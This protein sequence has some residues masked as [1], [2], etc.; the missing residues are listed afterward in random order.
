MLHGRAKQRESNGLCSSIS[1]SPSVQAATC[2]QH[3]SRPHC[4]LPHGQ[5][6]VGMGLQKALGELQN[7]S[8]EVIGVA[9]ECLI[10]GDSVAATVPAKIPHLQ[11][12][13]SSFLPCDWAQLAWQSEISQLLAYQKRR[14]SALGRLTTKLTIFRVET[15]SHEVP[16]LMAQRQRK[17]VSLPESS[18]HSQASVWVR[19][20]HVTLWYFIYV[21]VM[22]ECFV[23]SYSGANWILSLRIVC[24]SGP[25]KHNWRVL[26]GRKSTT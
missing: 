25:E 19:S 8:T 14:L 4:M 13:H 2:H 22:F 5:D 26:M 21:C 16:K 17:S 7:R 23:A 12:C 9:S 1:Q 10:S 18:W 15:R 20:R 3:V 24:S 11:Q 6:W